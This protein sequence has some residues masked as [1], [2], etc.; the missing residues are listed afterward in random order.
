MTATSTKKTGLVTGAG[1][2]IGR[3][4]AKALA[5]TGA[6][7]AVLDT[8]DDAASET[9]EMIRGDGG[10]AL[11][12]TVDIAD[13]RSVREAMDTTA[14]AYGSL[15]FAV[16]N[17][18]ITSHGTQL[19]E[20]TTDEFERL[21]RVNLTGTFLCMRQ[22]LPLLP[23][24]GAIVN[25]ASNGGLHAIPSAPGYVA[26]KHGV[27][28]LTKVAAVDYA[29]RGVRVNAVCPGP[30]R[31]RAFEEA[32]AET[33]MLARQQAN[34]PLAR[35]ATPDEPAAAAVWLCSDAASYVTGIALPVDGGRRT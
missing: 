24:G 33:G 10:E 18:G 32:A 21:L 28:G 7:V 12:V 25:I 26:A 31:T 19:H 35:I 22:E 6:A 11:T 3:A 15:D 34:T 14:A 2:G 20:M 5:A 29:D 4:T 27:V 23:S 13:E 17:A 30:T 16:N 8:D 9:T 1:S